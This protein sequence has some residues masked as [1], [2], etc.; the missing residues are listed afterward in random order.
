MLLH[1]GAPGF[2]NACTQCLSSF[3]PPAKHDKTAFPETLF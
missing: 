3:A 2:K 1:L